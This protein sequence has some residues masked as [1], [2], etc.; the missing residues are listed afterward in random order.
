[1]H[2]IETVQVVS[3]DPV[4]GAIIKMIQTTADQP[5]YSRRCAYNQTIERMEK[6]IVE[7]H[8]KPFGSSIPVSILTLRYLGAK[9]LKSTL[10]PIK[11]LT[12]S[13]LSNDPMGQ[14]V[15]YNEVQRIKKLSLISTR[16]VIYYLQV[17]IDEWRVYTI[18]DL[19]TIVILQLQAGLPHIT[20][21]THPNKSFQENDAHIQRMLALLKE[22]QSAFGQF[23]PRMKKKDGKLTLAKF[24]MSSKVIGILMSGVTPANAS[25]VYYYSYCF[26]NA[27]KG[28]LICAADVEDT[29]GDKQQRLATSHAFRRFA[30]DITCRKVT[31]NLSG[32]N[33]PTPPEMT[34]IYDDNTAGMLAETAQVSWHGKSAVDLIMENFPANTGLSFRE[35]VIAFNFEEL[36]RTGIKETDAILKKKHT[37]YIQSRV[38]L[39]TFYAL[40]T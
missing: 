11:E 9:H 40:P 14:M 3:Q 16:V 4:T 38:Y 21:P 20:I 22:N 24:F 1:M 5:F 15:F 32:F 17:T 23:H 28:K 10:I 2:K 8:G 30:F 36:N 35:Y 25:H 6:K 27:P 34:F 7:Y 39:Q 31:F 13:R 37:D 19:E 33:F 26:T 18:K 29:F 12:A